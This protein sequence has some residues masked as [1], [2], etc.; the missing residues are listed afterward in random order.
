MFYPTLIHPNQPSASSEIPAGTPPLPLDQ[1]RFRLQFGVPHQITYTL[2]QAPANASGCIRR[3][4]GFFRLMQFPKL[5]GAGEVF[6]LGQISIQVRSFPVKMFGQ[7]SCSID[8][9]RLEV[10][11]RGNSEI[12]VVDS[13]SQKIY[14][15]YFLTAKVPLPIKRWDTDGYS[16]CIPSVRGTPLLLRT[17]VKCIPVPR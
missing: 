9:E 15:I 11:G 6:F 13:P 1:K 4:R 3:I 17:P 8:T 14:Q 10:H 16:L 7:F 2:P 5:V 12:A